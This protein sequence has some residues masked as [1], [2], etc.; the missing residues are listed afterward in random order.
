MDYYEAALKRLK[1]DDTPMLQL[2][3]ETGV[4]WE[5]IRDVK[6]GRNKNV[7]F[8]TVKKLAHHY[9]PKQISA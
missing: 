4:P 1:A 2:E 5:T 9:F 7:Y 3:R 8:A 6:Y